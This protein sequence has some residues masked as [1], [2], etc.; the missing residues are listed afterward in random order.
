MEEHHVAHE[1][2]LHRSMHVNA[3]EISLIPRSDLHLFSGDVHLR[4]KISWCSANALA[5]RQSILLTVGSV[6]TTSSAW[7]LGCGEDPNS[8]TL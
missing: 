3:N 6:M 8:A 7:Q 4:G 1:P 2:G 5:A